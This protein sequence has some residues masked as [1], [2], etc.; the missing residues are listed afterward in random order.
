MLY[1]L[2]GGV[3]VIYASVLKIHHGHGQ[4]LVYLAV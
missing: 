3:H 2:E 1:L 4:K